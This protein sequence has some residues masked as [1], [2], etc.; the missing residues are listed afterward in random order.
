MTQNQHHQT[1]QKELKAHFVFLKVMLSHWKGL[2]SFYAAVGIVTVVILLLLP[3]WYRSTATVVILQDGGNSGLSAAI[4][5][6]VPFTLGLQGMEGA[7]KYIGYLNTRKVVDQV[8]D[9]FDLMEAYAIESR[10]IARKAV[11]NNVSFNDRQDGSFTISFMYKND[12]EKSAAIVNFMYDRIYTISLEVARAE[13]SNYRNYLEDYFVTVSE[14]LEEDERRLMNIQ[15]QT[16]IIELEDQARLAFETL[17]ELETQ[18]I[19]SEIEL[20]YLRTI[21]ASDSPQIRR[22]EQKLNTLNNTIRDFRIADGTSFISLDSLPEQGLEYLRAYRD[23]EVGNRV[24][25]F[26][27]LQYE[28]AM[29]EENKTSANLYLL[30][31]AQPP[32]QKYK[33]KR[34]QILLIVMFFTGILSFVF[35]RIKL[36]YRENRHILSSYLH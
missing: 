3:F 1:E 23:V 13:A 32:D 36:F 16:G 15:Q 26:I 10:D 27:R 21:V 8:I 29:L 28:E 12:P 9:E 33:P 11:R 25:E 17:S 6:M 5:D 20:D 18:R 22:S 31:P 2:L 24:F 14:Q 34:A 4:S 7:E 30:D 35:L 19:T